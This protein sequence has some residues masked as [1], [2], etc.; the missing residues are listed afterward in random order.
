MRLEVK[1]RESA[2]ADRRD[3]VIEKVR[4]LCAA[5]LGPQFP[6]EKDPQL[7]SLFKAE[8]VPEDRADELVATLD[9]LDDV[10]FAERAPK[11]RLI[12]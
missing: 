11:R 7:A 8:G 1:F 2:P 6:G 10:E 5:E 4:D 9:A 3:E 12:G